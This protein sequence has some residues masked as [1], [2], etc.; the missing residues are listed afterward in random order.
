MGLLSV[1]SFVGLLVFAAEDVLPPGLVVHVPADGL[2]DAV[3]KLGLGQPAQLIVNEGWVDG[4]ALVV[5][6]AVSHI[7][8]EVFA[9]A[10]CGNDELDDIADYFDDL[11]SSE[12]DL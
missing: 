7:S 1:D 5:P 11:F 2:F 10:C 8:D 4:V 9:L 3:F 6:L 12:I